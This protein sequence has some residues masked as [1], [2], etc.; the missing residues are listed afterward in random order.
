MIWTA[1][2]GGRVAF[3]YHDR[4]CRIAN[5][6]VPGIDLVFIIGVNVAVE[7]HVRQRLG[8]AAP[9]S[10]YFAKSS[11]LRSSQGRLRPT[12]LVN[13]LTVLSQSSNH[14]AVMIPRVVFS[15]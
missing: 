8:G 10:L 3:S 4:G 9:R 14:R 7:V 12:N 11:G 6:A 1:F 2:P 5:G 15:S 13:T